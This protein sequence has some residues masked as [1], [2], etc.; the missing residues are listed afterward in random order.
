[1][2]LW[3]CSGAGGERENRTSIEGSSGSRRRKVDI[4]IEASYHGMTFLFIGRSQRSVVTPS[5]MPEGVVAST[6]GRPL[7]TH[8]PPISRDSS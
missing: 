8:F 7:H 4:V 6:H 3:R 5:A 2:L 1:M